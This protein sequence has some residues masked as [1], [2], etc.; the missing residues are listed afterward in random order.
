MM[1]AN[2]VEVA[3]QK[4]GA[5]DGRGYEADYV[6]LEMKCVQ[7]DCSFCNGTGWAP[8]ASV[9][10]PSAPM[11]EE[12]AG[13]ADCPQCSHAPHVGG[14]AI[15]NPSDSTEICGCQHGAPT[16]EGAGEVKLNQYGL[17]GEEWTLLVGFGGKLHDALMDEPEGEDWYDGQSLKIMESMVEVF[18]AGKSMVKND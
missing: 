15:R 6:G 13:K 2:E 7:V 3:K 17:T 9:R 16:L 4:C 14:C 1:E 8:S 18:K 5:C 11:R 12:E 10:L